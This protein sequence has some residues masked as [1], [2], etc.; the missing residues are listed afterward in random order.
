[1]QPATETKLIASSS[2]ATLPTHAQAKPV[3]QTWANAFN[4]TSK[5]YE[6][7][8]DAHNYYEISVEYPQIENAR[9]LATRR[10]N[11]WIGRKVLRDAARFRYLEQA[12]ER[13]VSKG[14]YPPIVEGLEISYIVYYSDNSLI[15][16]RLTHRVMEAGQMHP[17]N[18]YETINYDLKNG[19]LF[20]PQD[21]FKPGYLKALSAY[22]RTELTRQFGENYK[23]PLLVEG[24]EP[25]RGNFADW[26]IVPDGILISFEDYQ[27]GPHSMGQPSFVVPYSALIGSLKTKIHGQRRCLAKLNEICLS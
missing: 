7:K 12:T 2:P 24:T 25:K 6:D 13:H 8:H 19:K 27:V 18:Y 10:F 16:L 15:S 26:N 17:I 21:V 20:R 4:F 1:L 5:S 9:S 3:E 11:L 14:K 22:C 23:D